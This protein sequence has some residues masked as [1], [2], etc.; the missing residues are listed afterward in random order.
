MKTFFF[1]QFLFCSILFQSE[2]KQ[3]QQQQQQQTHSSSSG[4][5]TPAWGGIF[6]HPTPSPQSSS[7]IFWGTDNQHSSSASKSTATSGT[8]PSYVLILFHTL[9]IR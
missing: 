8:K 2:P 1:V 7:S 9:S 5:S 6:Q 4:H 3:P